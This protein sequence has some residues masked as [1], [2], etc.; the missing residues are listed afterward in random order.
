MATSA[1]TAIIDKYGTFS[2]VP[3]LR[4]FD[5]P[6]SVEGVQVFPPYSVLMDEGLVPHYELEY[7]VNEITTLT[8]TVYCDTLAEVDA[9]V[10]IIKYNGGTTTGKLGLDFGTLPTLTIPYNNLVVMRTGERRF[11]VRATGKDGQRVHACELRYEVSLYRYD[12]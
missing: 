12:T 6:I 10:E 9:A 8:I 4:T 1:I 7:T 11:A 5:E 3:A 2:N